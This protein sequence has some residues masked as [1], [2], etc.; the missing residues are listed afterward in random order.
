MSNKLT[1]AEEVLQKIGASD[2]RSISKDQLISFVSSIP[3]MDK[4]TAIKCIEQFPEF[5]KQANDMIG[6]LYGF[7]DHLLEDHK[8]SKKSAVEAYRKILDDL[9]EMLKRPDLT[10]EQQNQISD[11]MIDVADRI[12]EVS[13]EN[14]TFLGNLAK[15]AGTV[16]AFVISIG[17]T[18]LGVKYL[19][20]R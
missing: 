20:R 1:S 15:L 11:K 12:A 16:A 19:D 5:S 14:D 6:Q 4:E 7:C 13:R 3:D 9:S 18:I 8:T 10:L 17:G 2:F